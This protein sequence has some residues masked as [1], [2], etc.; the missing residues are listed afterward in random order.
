VQGVQVPIG[1][2][3]FPLLQNMKNGYGLQP[4]P[5]SKFTNDLFGGKWVRA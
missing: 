5:Y 1:E 4:A 2:K 3:G